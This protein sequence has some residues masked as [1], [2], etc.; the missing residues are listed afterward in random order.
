MV[1]T[2]LVASRR[3]CSAKYEPLTTMSRVCSLPAGSQ[4]LCYLAEVVQVV[5]A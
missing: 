4:D 1:S 5:L 3:P 2:S